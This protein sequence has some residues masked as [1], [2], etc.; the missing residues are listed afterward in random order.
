VH[1]GFRWGNLSETGHFEELVVDGRVALKHVQVVGWGG[2]DWIDLAPDRGRVE[3]CCESGNEP[4]GHVKCGEFLDLL[5][6]G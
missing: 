3:G 1:T 6:T 5:W 4:Y 2:M